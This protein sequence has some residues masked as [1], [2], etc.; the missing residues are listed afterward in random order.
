[1]FDY[2]KNNKYFAQVAGT[3]ERHAVEELKEFGAEVIQEIPRGIRFSCNQETLYRIVYCSRLIQRVLVPIIN[4]QCHSEKYLYQ[5]SYKNVDWTSIF[6]LNESFSI[7]CNV[8]KSNISHS[9]YASQLLKD[10]ICDQFRDKFNARPNFSTKDADFNLSLHISDNH[11]TISFDAAGK[12]MHKRGYRKGSNSAPMQETL[13][14]ALVRLSGWDGSKP[15]YDVMCGSGTILAEA[16]M[17]YCHIPAGYLREDKGLKYLP[18]FDSELWE[19]IKKEENSKIIALPNGL[20]NGSDISAKSIEFAKENLLSLP[21]GNK[22]NLKTASFQN[23]EK[24]PE[25][26]IISNPPY[27]VRL[28]ER[29]NVGKLYNELGDFL[30]QKCPQSEAYILC[31]SNDL[32]S[33]LRLRAHWKKTLKNGDI[34]TKFAKIIMK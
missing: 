17:H 29:E 15:L 27:G 30:K 10:A 4:F 20:I 32:V 22:I 2:L 31:G 19:K 21:S 26:V 23:L 28:G 33:A 16:L 11:A 13:A 25:R 8:S 5:Q 6:D 3:I 34:E 7:D 1:V 9:L 12:S 18:D 14:A 24:I